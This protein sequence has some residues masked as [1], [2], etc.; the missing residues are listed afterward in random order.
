MCHNT[1]D[2]WDSSYLKTKV[3]LTNTLDHRVGIVTRESSPYFKNPLGLILFVINW[4]Q[5]VPKVKQTTHYSEVNTNQQR[6][7]SLDHFVVVRIKVLYWI[8]LWNNTISFTLTDARRKFLWPSIPH[9]LCSCC[10]GCSIT[11]SSV[12]DPSTVL[13]LVLATE[14]SH[15]LLPRL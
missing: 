12:R 11:V 15:A 10:W 1:T 14:G 5:W 6:C 9:P 4:S 3:C 7:T 13:C 2:K 8:I